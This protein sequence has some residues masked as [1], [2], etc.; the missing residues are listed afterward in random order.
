[1]HATVSG[2]GDQLAAD[3]A[4]AI[5]QAKQYFSYLPQN[6]RGTPR[7]YEPAPRAVSSPTIWCRARSPVDTTSRQ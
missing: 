3:D 6:W 5:A 7:N 4:D 2:C 1:M